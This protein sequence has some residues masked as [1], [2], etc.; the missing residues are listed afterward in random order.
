[1]DIFRCL[2]SEYLIYKPPLVQLLQRSLANMVCAIGTAGPAPSGRCATRPAAS[3]TTAAQLPTTRTVPPWWLPTLRPW[4]P[5]SIWKG[6]S[7]SGWFP[8]RSRAVPWRSRRV[9][10][11]PVRTATSRLV[12]TWAGLQWSS[13]SFPSQHAH[14]SSWFPES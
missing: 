11:A 14:G 10:H 13:W 7:S 6:L 4:W 8:W 1:V 12:P 5:G 9:W 3:A 2:P